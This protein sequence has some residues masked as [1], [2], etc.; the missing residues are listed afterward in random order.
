MPYSWPA[1]VL[2]IFSYKGRFY[3]NELAGYH[4]VTFEAQCGGTLIDRKT[5]LTAAHCIVTEFDYQI[6]YY[7][8]I[9][10]VAPTTYYSTVESMYSV[11]TGVND[12][13]V[14]DYTKMT[15][16]SVAKITVVS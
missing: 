5:V 4:D 9:I 15:K 6:S 16:S 7:T 14:V 12:V 3:F 1:S 13:T 11:Y 2:L 10:K 8:Y